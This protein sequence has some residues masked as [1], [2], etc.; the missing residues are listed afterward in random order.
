MQDEGQDGEHGDW[1]IDEVETGE[2]GTLRWSATRPDTLSDD[3]AYGD[4][5]SPGWLPPPLAAPHRRRRAGVTVPAR[6]W[7]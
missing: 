1:Q 4:Q 6:G 7:R 5:A 3:G 2:E